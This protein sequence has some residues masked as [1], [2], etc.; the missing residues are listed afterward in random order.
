MHLVFVMDPVSTVIV[1][2]DTS[3]ALM[4]EAQ[5]SGHRVDHCG[6]HDLCLRDGRLFARVRR[7]T[8]ERDPDTPIRLDRAEEV[9]LHNVDAVF[10]RKDPPFDRAYLWCTLMLDRVVTETLVVNRPSGLRAA[11][12]K[13][14]AC[15]FPEL[16]PATLVAAGKDRIREF[17]EDVGGRAVIKPLD[18]AGGEGGMALASDDLNFNAIIEAATRNGRRVAM[19]Q[20]FLPEV[21]SGDKRILLLDGEPLGAILRIPQRGDVRSNIHVGGSVVSAQIDEADRRI[22]E[23]VAPSLRRDGLFFVGL[24][25]IGG[26]LT[27][28]NVT[29]PT[30]IQQMSRLDT[31]NYA[32]RVIAWTAERV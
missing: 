18:G 21:S 6:A 5:D 2:E 28:V 25:V 22:I 26:H 19:V 13:L 32:S 16:M 20:A 3:F 7:A 10:I 1:D 15:S 27:E 4:L 14:Y 12:E 8:M 23:T 11:N 30:G 29:S 31:Q 17:V 24:D 9:C